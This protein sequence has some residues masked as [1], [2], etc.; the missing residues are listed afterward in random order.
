MPACSAFLSAFGEITGTGNFHSTGTAPFFFPKLK[1]E[2]LGELAF[3]IPPSQ[4]EALIKLAEAAP[5]GMGE[6]TVLD[7][8]VRKCWQLDAA[9][10]SFKSPQWQKFL[11]ATVSRIRK[12]LG[13]KGK[14]SASPYKLLV[15]GKG[16]HFKAHRDTEKL[17]AMFGTLIIALPSAHE[18]GR[19]F[20]RHDGR[21]FEVDFSLVDHLHE[22]QHA[23]FFADCEHE[24]APIVSGYRC[25]LVYNLCL[26]EGDPGQL[27]L[28]QTAQVRALLPSLAA[29]KSER[30][31]E[32]STVL[33][34]HSY[35]EANLSLGNLK[36][37]DLARAQALFAAAKDAGFI[38]HLA[39]VTFHQVGDL[40][41]TQ[42]YRRRGRNEEDEPED[43]TMGEIHDEDLVIGHWRTGSDRRV[44]LGNYRIDPEVLISKDEIDAGE[45]DE[46]QAEGYTGNAGCTMEHWYRRAA[47]VLWAEEDHE[48]ILC[49]YDFR[50]ACAALAELAT[51][52]KT[53][54][55][56]PF[57]RLGKAVVTGFSEAPPSVR[58]FSETDSRAN[59]F[60]L[61]LAALATAGSLEL[62]ALLLARVP[63]A[64]FI[65][66]DASLWRKLHTAFGVEAFALVYDALL[67]DG[68]EENRRTLFQILD[69]LL[70]RKEG[71]ARARTIASRLARLAPQQ[72]PRHH[73][74]DPHRDPLPPGD[75]E[76]TRILLAASHLLEKSSERQAALAF[77]RADS[78]LNSI[79]EILGPILLEK[80]VEKLLVLKHSLAPEVLAVAQTSLAAEVARPLVPYP[81]W[82]RPCPRLEKENR[83]ASTGYGRPSVKTSEALSEL[84][85]FMAN[86]RAQTHAFRYSQ[87]IRSELEGFIRDHFLDL[88]H[89][90]I[91]QG[92]PHTLV[93]TKNEKSYAHALATRAKDETLLEK[94]KGL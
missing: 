33:L 78:S 22:F 69:G 52:K 31:G 41:E 87:D 46:A 91:R 25:C 4:A 42:D 60:A 48:R 67:A 6:K 35:T 19:L 62:L 81:D 94:L 92:T 86:P 83:T 51:E 49:R 57:H 36:G 38:A 9:N 18:G 54:V 90:T 20:I 47:I 37:N 15:Y 30:S 26:E 85:S 56:T 68:P 7:E 71:A 55:G 39:L 89:T 93:C 23:A 88:D 8:N 11:E 21:E 72:Q 50:G 28:P 64:P 12:D 80:P 10:F 3:P 27:N 24:V 43:G 17:V 70:A 73:Y 77:I 59:P 61:T 53:G 66:C 14:V 40:E 63:A 75:R 1:V 5:Y 32:L 65:Q 13:I 58:H 79:R 82:T 16:G 76:E 34:E 44:D 74:S 45:P 2:G 84:A 29:M